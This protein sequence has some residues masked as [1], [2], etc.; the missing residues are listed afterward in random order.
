MKKARITNRNKIFNQA[1]IKFATDARQPNDPSCEAEVPHSLSESP[2]ADTISDM[3]RSIIVESFKKFLNDKQEKFN[4]DKKEIIKRNND[5]SKSSEEHLNRGLKIID[6]KLFIIE[7]ALLD[8]DDLNKMKETNKKLYE[9]LLN[10]DPEA[11]IN[12]INADLYKVSESENITDLFYP[13][14]DIGT[15]MDTKE[16]QELI[17]ALYSNLEDMERRMLGMPYLVKNMLAN[18]IDEKYN[19]Q[20]TVI[21]SSY[22]GAEKN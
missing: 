21:L 14:N 9:A 3:P 18:I 2:R 8:L 6:D 12:K 22:E 7:N 16:I 1:K 19:D 17:N 5:Y 11:A 20:R 4:S 15:M 10:S 13:R